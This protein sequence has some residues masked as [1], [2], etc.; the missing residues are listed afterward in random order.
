MLAY[1]NAP[2][3]QKKLVVVLI[4]NGLM[5][6]IYFKHLL[7]FGIVWELLPYTLSL[8]YSHRQKSSGSSLVNAATTAGHTCGRSVGQG[9]TAV[10]MPMICLRCGSCTILLEPLEDLDNPSPLTKCCPELA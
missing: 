10:S 6:K 4:F 1:A 8:R 5:L 9:N 7:N 2:R 3:V